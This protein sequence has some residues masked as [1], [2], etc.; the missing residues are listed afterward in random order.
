MN[1][2]VYSD[3]FKVFLGL[4]SLLILGNL[5][6]GN[7]YATVWN[8]TEA[9][10]FL[11]AQ[12]GSA[13]TPVS[14][15]GQ[16]IYDLK[17]LSAFTMR[18][19]SVLFLLFSGLVFYKYGKKIFGRDAVVLTMLVA[20]SSFLLITLAK[21]GGGDLYLLFAQ[22]GH[23]IFTI[24]FV[25]QPKSKWRNT[26][27]VFL[28]LGMLIHP[29]SMGNWGLAFA[30]ILGIRHSKKEN[31][32]TLFL[33]IGL[34]LI[35]IP[36]VGSFFLGAWDFSE[37]SLSYG[38]WSVSSVFGLVLLGMLPWLG[39][40]PAAIV[41]L[42]KK[43]QNGEELAIIIFAWLGAAIVSQSLSLVI[44][45]SFMITKQIW[46]LF[47]SGYPYLRLVKGFALLNLIAT[48]CLVFMTLLGGISWVGVEGYRPLLGLSAVYW[49]LSLFGVLGLFMKDRRVVIG[50][51]TFS[52]LMV[53]MIF[54]LAVYP[55][56]DAYRK[57]PGQVVKTA[58]AKNSSGIEKLTLYPADWM[59][60]NFRV[61]AQEEFTKIEMLADSTDFKTQL[62]RP[63]HQVFVFDNKV[64]TEVDSMDLKGG[65]YFEVKGGWGR[66]GSGGYVI[67][68][69]RGN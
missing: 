29:L 23:L 57:L 38:Q 30:T 26:S 6:L 11:T 24:L 39:F 9:A 50:G 59:S 5:F 45:L 42:F 20:A 4:C 17:G 51:A 1:Q 33:P 43:F 67:G 47:H 60:D 66:M 7:D 36:M 34:A 61:Y 63:D 62:K 56:W 55:L 49:M 46:V 69:G 53:M 40:L 16:L 52:G 2:K 31:V 35:L 27:Y 18:L 15:I 64:L 14:F 54:W 10:M 28:A 13:A 65:E 37:F 44:V 32:K 68:Q 48:F 3:S 19:P 41:D 58:A 8:G 21:I 25:K 22:V 12:N